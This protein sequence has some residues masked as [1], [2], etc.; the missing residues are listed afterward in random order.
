[1][2]IYEKNH[3]GAGFLARIHANNL[4]YR[5]HLHLSFEFVFC[6]E[7]EIIVTISGK[8][9]MLKKNQGA[10]IPY[11]TIHS[12]QTPE[13]SDLYSLLVGQGLLR[14]I[15]NLFQQHLP[16]RYT[17]TIDPLL[18]EM[19]LDHY[20]SRDKQ[21]IFG[22]KAVLYRAFDAFMTDNAFQLRDTTDHSIAAQL[23]EYI[24][25]HFQEQITLE[26]FARH[27]DYN[28][29]YASKLIKRNFG[30]SF[31]QLLTEYR[32][33]YAQELL[34]ESQLSISQIALLAG[35]GSIRNFNRTFLRSIGKTPRQFHTEGQ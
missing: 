29:F 12:Y 11:N 30:L 25:E 13:K 34:Q 17:F 8:E 18:R 22:A 33:N 32:L 35:F 19:I 23:P 16:I 28:Y 26:D 2:Q 24:Q 7:G 20:S 27:I 6:L 9:H 1:M 4:T 14:D 5:P 10:V 21:T 31:S 3:S 15:T